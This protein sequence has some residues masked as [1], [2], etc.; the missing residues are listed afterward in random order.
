MSARSFRIA[1][2]H[3]A[4]TAA[5]LEI[6]EDGGNAADA[7][8]GAI[9]TACV[10]E[11]MLASLGGGGHALIQSDDQTTDCLDFFTQTPHT[12]R[13][14]AL[15]FYPIVGN[16]GTDHQEFH[17]GLASVATPGVLAGL[18]ALS[19]RHGRLPK[20]RLIEPACR[21]AT[22]GVALNALQHHILEILEP[23][24]RSTP[25]ARRWAGI[26]G[27]DGP[28]PTIGQVISNRSLADFLSAWAQEGARVFY[29]G[30]VA[31]EF[32]Q[33][34]Q[35]LGGHLQRADFDGYQ[36]IWRTPLTWRYRDARLFSN[37]P[38]ALGGTMLALSTVG[39]SQRLQSDVSFGSPEHVEALVQSMH[40]AIDRRAQL[41]RQSGSE[42]ALSQA[43]ETI[44]DQHAKSTRGTT[45]ISID[46]GQGMGVSVTLSN[47]EGS[48]QVME[49]A[50]IMM[51]NMLGEEDLNRSG[52]HRWP[53]N[54]RL[55]SMMTPTIV[56]RDNGDRYLLGSG[57]SNRI[58]TA[59]M[60]V[61]ANVLDFDL[62]L[63]E[64]IEAPR[65]HLEDQHLS[66]EL[67]ERWDQ[68]TADWFLAHHKH[69]T[70]WPKRSLFFGG[71]HAVGPHG[72]YADTR[73]EGAA[74]QARSVI[75]PNV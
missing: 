44:I 31:A 13:Q 12:L 34:S 41:E 18:D 64:A 56:N 71:V 53:E 1:T 54:R 21:Y 45:H 63:Q 39:L 16:F 47:G 67:A 52:F 24:V 40:H 37:P 38:P 23:I 32:V 57:G 3:Q 59:L 9:L 17:V 20:S 60:Q 11:P 42:E 28:L 19:A 75:Q 58:R 48:G 29:Q 27:T 74:Y 30:P 43:I 65:I 22:Q 6:L 15:D 62:G 46:D 73:R 10:A 35:A 4:T 49:T 50:G 8:I 14:G 69:A 51:N 5:A 66:I 7:A 72:A 26:E 25:E 70:P 33:K 36:A 55:A 2:G 61:I 68:K